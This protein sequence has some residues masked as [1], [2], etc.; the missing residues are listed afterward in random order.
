MW[1]PCILPQFSWNPS[2]GDWMGLK[3]RRV[4]TI[5]SQYCLTAVYEDDAVSPGH[6]PAAHEARCNEEVL[7]M[8]PPSPPTPAGCRTIYT[9]VRMM[10][11][12]IQNSQKNL[13]GCDDGENEATRQKIAHSLVSRTAR[14][15]VW[16][17]RYDNEGASSCRRCRETGR[18]GGDRRTPIISVKLS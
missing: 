11:R 13:T 9:P 16:H 4:S 7:T 1:Q 15:K 18:G 14:W 6:N 5:R 10:G 2:P 12:Q 8:D 3:T 17:I